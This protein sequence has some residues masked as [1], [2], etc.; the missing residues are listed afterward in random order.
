M[1]CCSSSGDSMTPRYLPPTESPGVASAFFPSRGLSR[2]AP[3]SPDP[4]LNG[5]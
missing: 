4:E 1:T 5:R 3:S 2:N